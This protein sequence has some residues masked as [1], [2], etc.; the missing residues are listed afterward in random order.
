[1]SRP[2]PRWCVHA[3]VIGTVFLAACGWLGGATPTPTPPG[4]GASA[5]ASPAASPSPSPSGNATIISPAA[6]P[7]PGASPS[8]SPAAG[9]PGESYTVGDGDTL[10]SIADKYY[11]D[12]SQWRKIYD[13]NKAAIG[14]NPDN[15]KVGTKLTI[16]PK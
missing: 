8:P 7:S 6:S 13:A 2:R 9:G 11:G 15:V 5:A 12:A 1:M 14:D 10:A 3:L 16:P 4:A